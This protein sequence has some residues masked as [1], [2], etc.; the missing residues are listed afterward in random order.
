MSDSASSRTRTIA[1]QSDLF[2]A[3]LEF[4]GRGTDVFRRGGGERMSRQ[5]GVPFLGT[6]PL[7]A[8]IVTG[9]DEGRPI[10]LEKPTSFALRKSWD[11]GT[12]GLR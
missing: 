6:I 4:C 3:S 11:Q 2:Q 8:D 5:L 9:G 12:D 1:R 10:V 7:D